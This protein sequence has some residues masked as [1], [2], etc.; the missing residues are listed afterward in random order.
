MLYLRKCSRSTNLEKTLEL[1]RM[2]EPRPREC[3]SAGELRA[4]D[5][6]N[7]RSDYNRVKV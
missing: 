2:W 1:Y 3:K 4:A 7:T 6:G 5:G